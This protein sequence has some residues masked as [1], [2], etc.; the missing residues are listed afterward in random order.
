MSAPL[1]IKRT[2][3]TRTGVE[4]A[5]DPIPADERDAGQRV[6]P[7]E[8]L[9]YARALELAANGPAADE[10]PRVGCVILDRDGTIIA[11][12]WHRGKGTAHAEV[13]A[14][15]ALAGTERARG[16]T[17]VVTLEPCNHTGATGPCSAA[18][19]DAG[20]ARVVYSAS[21]P[22]NSSAGGAT[23][24]RAAGVD[25]VGGLER[26]RTEAF[27]RPWL[28]AVRRGRPF[29]TAKWASSLD[30]RAAAADGTSQWI[31]G[32]SAREDVHRRRSEHGAIVVG[33]GTVLADDPSLTA[34]DGNNGL[35]REQPL[36]VVI[37]SRAIP[38]GSRVLSHPAGSL[39]YPTNDLDSVLADLYHRGIR[40][41]F[42]EGGP[43]L[44]SAFVA[45]GLVDEFLVYLAPTLLGGGRLSIT[46][47][48]VG[49]IGEQIRL[50]TVSVE[51]LGDD[52]LV[53][54]RPATDPTA[55]AAAAPDATTLDHSTAAGSDSHSP[56]GRN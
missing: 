24:L 37:G 22:G 38:E 44:T 5:H 32:P 9:A 16:A 7:A 23:R 31:T 27:L 48:G 11:E 15:S 21:D 34:R 30:G 17:A 4:P 19:I 39:A 10:N 18:L 6:S 42:I 29:V 20:I 25:V 47:V 43:T 53:I 28:T 55:A 2:G 12:G 52:I 1:E 26:E 45:A 51:L 8:R 50:E 49:T 13:M 56:L 35:Y 41:V 3:A 14:L 33:T 54:A 40:E 36:P 46:D